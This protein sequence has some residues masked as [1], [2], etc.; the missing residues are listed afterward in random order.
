ME[1][2]SGIHHIVLGA[3]FIIVCAIYLVRLVNIQLVSSEEYAPAAIPDSLTKRTVVLAAQRGQIFDRN[4]KL[5][6]G[7]RYTYSI[8]LDAQRLGTN[9]AKNELL[10]EVVSTARS[11]E[12]EQTLAAQTV[13]FDGIYPNLAF[14]PELTD[15]ESGREKLAALC[16]KLKLA[17][18]ATAAEVAAA[19]LEKYALVDEGG[20]PLYDYLMTTQLLRIRYDM[21]ARSFSKLNPYVA[22][23]DVSMRFIT[24]IA[25]KNVTGYTVKTQAQRYYAYPGVASHILGRTGKIQASKLEY[26]TELGY[27]MDAVVGV[28]GVEEVFESYLRGVDGEMT[29]IEDGDGNI[30]EAYVS[31][32][33]VAGKSVW[34]TID[35]ELQKTAEAQLAENIAYVVEKGE[36]SGEKNNGQNAESGAIV[37]ADPNTGAVLTLASHPT[38]DLSEFLKNYADLSA[39]ATAPLFNRALSGTYAPGSTFKIATALAALENGIIG[40]ETVID[41]QGVYRFYGDYQPACWI[42]RQMHMVHGKIDITEAIKVSC[43]YFFYDIGRKLTI[44]KLNDY[45]TK[46]GLGEKTGIELEENS[47]ILA[48]PEYRELSGKEQWNPGNTLSAAIGQSDN[49]FTPMQLAMYMSTVV[50]GGTRYRAHLLYKVVNYATDEV[51]YAPEPEVLGTIEIKEENLTAVLEGMRGV[52]ENA[53]A[54][55]IFADTPVLVGGKTGT[56]EVSGDG[57]ANAVFTA[58]APYEAPEMVAVSII[59][60]GAS[61]INASYCIRDVINWYFGGAE[62]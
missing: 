49:A 37:I 4:G 21:E 58:F 24:T 61:G 31:K 13:L 55:A 29:L 57:G 52:I 3:F 18:G 6:V 43:N 26:Y 62:E 42:Y 22:A 10:A 38:Y 25:E 46:L 14:R 7:N 17:E 35:I 53:S 27:P 9:E 33:P 32:E 34:L 16:K 47:G 5:I 19:L 8:E 48:G 30:V 50:N 51:I 36:A 2:R 56:A 44:E 12:E 23:S 59:E 11:A 54:A 45:C 28:D 15:T 39:D 20:S 60:K 41:A 40:T 1:K